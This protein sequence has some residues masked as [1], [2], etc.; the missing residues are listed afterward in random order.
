MD[1]KETNKE[2]IVNLTSTQ[3]E[4]CLPK[5]QAMASRKRELIAQYQAELDANPREPITKPIPKLDIDPESQKFRKTPIKFFW[6]TEGKTARYYQW[7][8]PKPCLLCDS[9]ARIEIADKYSVVQFCELHGLQVALKLKLSVAELPS[10]KGSRLI[11]SR[12]RIDATIAVLEK[13]R[14]QRIAAK[15]AKE[16]ED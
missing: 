7:Q 3:I 14:D 11:M 16:E 4:N 8:L 12:K 1:K 2:S 10:V 5:L 13:L 9:Y 15:L 6:T